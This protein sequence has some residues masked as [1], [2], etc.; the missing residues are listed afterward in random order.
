MA[1]RLH[2]QESIETK[3]D[4]E[5]YSHRVG[6]KHAIHNTGKTNWS[7]NTQIICLRT[8]DAGLPL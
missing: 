1:K 5:K 8:L 3:E 6:L 7:G 4:A 2:W